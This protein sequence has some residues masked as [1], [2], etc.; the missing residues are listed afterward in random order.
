[1]EIKL[2]GKSL[3]SAKKAKAEA[4]WAEATS[5]KVRESKFLPDFHSK[6]GGLGGSNWAESYVVIESSTGGAVAVPQSK[7]PKG[8]GGAKID[9]RK[10]QIQLTPK[11]VYEGKFLNDDTFK[12]NTNEKYVDEQLADFKEKL[13][14]IKSEEYD[15]ANGVDEIS[16]II[17]R[18]E[19][20]KK[21]PEVREFFEQFPYTT[22]S[23]IAQIT[24]THDN[25]QLGQIA[26]FV[27]DMPKEAVDLMKQYNENTAKVCGK[28][29]VFYI[30][31]DKKDFKKSDQ[32][33]DP[34]L[35]AQSPF[36]HVWQIIG[37]WDKE[38]MFL[39]E[40]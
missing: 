3:F 6:R 21:Y 28:Q 8:K 38:M 16:S 15:M 39:E 24:K 20:R 1:M 7:M 2:F 4:L 23:K 32:R 5:P 26:Q 34:I 31:A 22:S 11:G 40:L 37:A 9:G 35:L 18:L 25:L 30:I 12:L 33:R 19:N 13:A 14:L 29:A 36:G 10:V 27:A 17:Q